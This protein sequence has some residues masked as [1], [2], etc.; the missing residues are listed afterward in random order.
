MWN[1]MAC[2]LAD[3]LIRPYWNS[4]ISEQLD[5]QAKPKQG[6]QLKILK[7]TELFME[8]RNT[9]KIKT[10]VRRG[11]KLECNTITQDYQFLILYVSK[12]VKGRNL[13][14][15]NTQKKYGRPHIH[16]SDRSLNLGTGKNHW[17]PWIS[18]KLIFLSN[19]WKVEFEFFEKY[20]KRMPYYVHIYKLISNFRE[21]TID[22]FNEGKK[23]PS[24]T[25]SSPKETL[26]NCPHFFFC[27]LSSLF[28]SLVLFFL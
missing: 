5:K 7:T 1:T 12:I 14:K 27:H 15:T 22:S 20:H 11:A 13:R 21:L 24:K 16:G 3:L 9:P 6:S 2:H 18:G 28:L 19:L 26:K 4:I 23:N 25:P 8:A 10:S 17:I